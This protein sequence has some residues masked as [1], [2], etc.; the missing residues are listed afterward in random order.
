LWE[1]IKKLIFVFQILRIQDSFV[2]LLKL[3]L[4]EITVDYF[5]L[6]SSEKGD[7]ILHLYLKKDNIIY[8]VFLIT[9]F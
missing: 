4:P 2:E 7:E 1:N 3:L 8:P 6:T 9:K 5:E